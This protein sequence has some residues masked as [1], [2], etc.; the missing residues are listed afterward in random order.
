MKKKTNVI[1]RNIKKIT[2][3]ISIYPW[4]LLLLAMMNSGPAY[5]ALAAAAM[6]ILLFIVLSIV[7]LII[8]VVII[9]I[10]DIS[11]PSTPKSYVAY[12]F[13]MN[14]VSLLWLLLLFAY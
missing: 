2:A 9:V 11:T 7:N 4:I 1:T 5:A 6:V 10:A 14:S 12:F 3:V 8:S 13:A